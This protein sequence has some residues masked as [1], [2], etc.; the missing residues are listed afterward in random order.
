M[1]QETSPS[2]AGWKPFVRLILQTKPSKTL[3]ALALSLNLVTTLSG[4][5][6]PLLTKHVVDN[7]SLANL[8]AVQMAGIGLA[9]IAQAVT[10]GIST[11]L[12]SR[13]GQQIVSNLRHRLWQKLLKLPVS[14]YDEHQTGETISRMTND[15]GVLKGLITEHSA[16]FFT[17]IIS[18]VG[19]L[20]MLFYLDWKMTLLLLIA[21]PLASA[22]LV[23]LGR[24]MYKISKGLQ[25]ETADFTSVL[26]R[27][28]SEIRLVKASNA[29][30]REFENGSSGILKLLRYGI[31]EGK[32][33]AGIAPV[34]S[35]VMMLMFVLIIGYGG[36]RVSSGALTAGA[37]VAFL[38]YLFQI[39][40]PTTQITQ[41]FTQF[42]KAKGATERI[43]E[44]LEAEEES[45]LGLPLE[46]AD[47]PI[48]LEGVS[49]AYKG[50]EAVLKQVTFTAEPGKVTAIVGPSG[51]GKTTLFSLLERFYSPTGGTIKLGEVPI[52]RYALPSWRSRIGYVSQESPLVEG[53]IRENISYGLDREVTPAELDRAAQMAY[54]DEFI[55]QLP[56]GYETE[57]GERGLK[58]S[59]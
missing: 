2:T 38:L 35:F 50:G 44:T 42:Q 32:V 27:V 55:G 8:N 11:Y 12:L 39:V 23:P 53:T 51:S 48:V 59:G 13:I 47:L 29:E 10:A 4:L 33:Q 30:T 19:S 21:I 5:V 6:I 14:Y 34:M 1:T 37:L 43:I 22:V 3:L 7:F 49:F 56:G 58:L 18:I 41:F 16:N 15:T 46:R 52:D 24:Q 9:F 54:A 40:L 20:V 45:V 31:R 36:L 28:L 26:T 17:G 25:D 57:V